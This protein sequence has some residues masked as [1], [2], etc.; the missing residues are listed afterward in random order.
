MLESDPTA[1]QIKS[2]EYIDESPELHP[3][4]KICLDL[5]VFNSMISME[6]ATRLHNTHARLNMYIYSMYSKHAGGQIN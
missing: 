6:V 5:P 1:L 3:L 2:E 4:S